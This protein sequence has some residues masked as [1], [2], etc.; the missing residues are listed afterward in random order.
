VR[1]FAVGPVTLVAATRLSLQSGL[2]L[3]V[4]AFGP[5]GLTY[6]LPRGSGGYGPMLTQANIRLGASYRHFD[7]T[8]D[9]LNIFDRRTAENQA[10][11]YSDDA[12]HPIDGGTSEDLVFLKNDFGRPAVRLNTFATASE[13]QPPFMAVLGIQRAF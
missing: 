7:V 4:M 3:D 2:P 5:D 6:L 8:L 1:H 10:A 12:V 11:I 13:F 9:F